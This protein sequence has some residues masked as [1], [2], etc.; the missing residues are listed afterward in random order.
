MMAY[1]D[2]SVI[3]AKYFP[4]DKFHAEAT[5]FLEASRKRKII[6]PVSAVEL[7]AVV[8][9]LEKELQA[10][11]EIL[12]EPPRRRNRALVEFFIKDCNLQVANVNAYAKIKLAGTTL[13]VPLEYQ[14]CIRWAHALKLKT[15]DL[16]HLV[17]ADNLRKWGYDLDTFVTGDSKR[18]HEF[19][20]HRGEPWAQSG[21]AIQRAV[22]GTAHEA[23]FAISPLSRWSTFTLLPSS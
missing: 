19:Q 11:Q 9:R 15:L 16:I 8:S 23:L 2:T 22:K 17:Y 6:S 3:L 14:S 20:Q 1:I 4:Q 12:A 18:T 5:G 13:P 7:A 21:K 10:P